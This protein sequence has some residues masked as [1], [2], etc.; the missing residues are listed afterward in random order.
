MFV[1]LLRMQVIETFTN[2]IIEWLF[3]M[4]IDQ[5]DTQYAIFLSICDVISDQYC[6]GIFYSWVLLLRVHGGNSAVGNLS[7]WS[8]MICNQETY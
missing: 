1:I 3:V 8:I 4:I 6:L 5:Y 7:A 2:Y